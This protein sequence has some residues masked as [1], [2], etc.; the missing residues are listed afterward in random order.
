VSGNLTVTITA[1]SNTEDMAST[2]VDI[3]V[4]QPT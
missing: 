3:A 4:L 1:T 2:E